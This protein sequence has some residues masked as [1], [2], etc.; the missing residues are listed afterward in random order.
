MVRAGKT[1]EVIKRLIRV[2]QEKGCKHRTIVVV[3]AYKLYETQSVIDEF[4]LNEY[5]FDR[6]H[7]RHR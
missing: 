5:H 1:S 3:D 4:I 6:P 2:L 7:R